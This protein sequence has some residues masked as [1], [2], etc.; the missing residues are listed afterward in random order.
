[1]VLLGKTSKAQS[2]YFRSEDYV[3]VCKGY[4]H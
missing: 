2:V 4:R 3:S 1:M